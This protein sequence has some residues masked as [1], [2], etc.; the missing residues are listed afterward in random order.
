MLKSILLTG[1]LAAVTIAQPNRQPV[2]TLSATPAAPDLIVLSVTAAGP[3]GANAGTVTV[4]VKNQG[5]A[6][7]APCYMAIRITTQKGD[8]QGDKTKVYSPKVP[9]LSPGQ[10]T[11]V[12]GQTEFITSVLKKADYEVTVDR[13]NTVKESNENNN[14]LK[15]TFT[16]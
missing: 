16:P 15:G 1:V 2:S 13:S 9:A 14:T 7:A 3:A 10:E 12:V 8:T 5:D 4:R 6:S 11:E